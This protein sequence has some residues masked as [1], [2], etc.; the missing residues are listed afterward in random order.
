MAAWKVAP[1]LAAGC[2]VIL[3]PSE[4]TPLTAYELTAIISEAGVPAGVFNLVR[5]NGISLHI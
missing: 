1:A 4:V 2:S 3:K 5:S